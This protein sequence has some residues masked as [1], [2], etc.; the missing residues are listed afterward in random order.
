M[1]KERKTSFLVIVLM[2]VII[3]LI[4]FFLGVK[5]DISFL[6]KFIISLISLG[7]FYFFARKGFSRFSLFAL[8]SIT[9]FAGLTIAFS[10]PNTGDSPIHVNFILGVWPIFIIALLSSLLILYSYEKMKSNSRYEILLFVVYLIFW[11]LIAINAK[12]FDGW[13][14]ENFLVLPFLI[15]IYFL[16]RWFKFSKLSYSLIFLFMVLHVVG[17]HYTYSEVPLGFWM[18]NF[19][20][21]TRNHYDRIVHFA[22]GLLWAYPI[23]EISMR[24]G[25]LKGF[26][27]V[28]IPIEF[29]LALSCV[30]ELIEWAFAVIFGGDLGI[31]YLGTQGDVWDAQ[32]DMALAGL[33]SIL[34]M[35]ITS[36]ILLYYNATGFAKEFKESLYVKSQKLLGEEALI[37]LIDRKEIKN[38]K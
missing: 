32:K 25:N 23:R 2:L 13:K 20:N 3:T 33:G 34:T 31:A 24:I 5:F 35:I 11:I 28:W 7:F 27:A 22:F 38:K 10:T 8:A 21:L 18:Q 14:S 36:S 4:Y 6:E 12:Y 15:I 30:F 16:H 17:S 1:K 37:K 29:V 26:W 19:F 9:L